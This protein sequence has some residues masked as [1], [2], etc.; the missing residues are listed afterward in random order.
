M[1][2]NG[3]ST[4]APKAVDTPRSAVPGSSSNGP[5][6]TDELHAAGIKARNRDRYQPRPFCEGDIVIPGFE[7]PDGQA[8]PPLTLAGELCAQSRM[9]G[10]GAVGDY[11]NDGL[12]DIFITSQS[13]SVCLLWCIL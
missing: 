11:N 9:A 12:E 6:F 13:G 1:Q 8:E 2:H 3:T 4:A 10:G 5:V 7:A